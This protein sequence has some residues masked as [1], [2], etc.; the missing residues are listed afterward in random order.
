MKEWDFARNKDLNPAKLTAGS[1]KKAWWVCSVCGH[2]WQTAIYHRATKNTGCPN[3]YCGKR[4][5]FRERNLSVTHPEIAEDW[6]IA[7]NGGVTPEM[8]TKNS[9]Y[10]ASWKCAMCGMEYKSSVKNYKGCSQCR[11]KERLRNSNLAD[12]FPELAAEW[13]YERN[14]LHPEDFAPHSNQ[15][16]WWLCTKCG[17]NWR[18]KI[19]NRSAL[20]RNCP[21][22]AGR[23]VVTG[24]NDLATTHPHLVKEWHPV[25]N[26]ILTPQNVTHGSGKKVWWQCPQGH[27]YK[28]VILHRT[29]RESAT[30]CPICYSGRQTSFAEQATFYYIKKAFPDAI[31]RYKAAFLERFELDIFI[32]SINYAIEY[33]GEAWHKKDKILREQKK[34]EICRKHGIKLI[35]LRE[36]SFDT[37][38][39][40]ADFEIVKKDLYKHPHL[41]L[42]VQN[43]FNFLKNVCLQ[44]PDIDI[45]GDKIKVYQNYRMPLPDSFLR[46]FPHIAKEWH[47]VKNDILSPDMFKPYSDAKVWWQCA[48]CGHEWNA[49]IGHRASGTGCPECAIEKT[50]RTT[51]KAVYMIDMQTNKM[52]K[53]FVSISAAARETQ[54][55]SSNITMVCKGIRASAGGYVWKY[56]ED[57][58]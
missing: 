58:D 51:R 55:N 29:S 26:H 36:K 48:E 21:C 33:D 4:A 38:I 35:R 2:K 47:P 20:R 6:D 18:A 17:Y 34:Y 3:C 15:S 16:V 14:Q 19:S 52:I 40:I 5:K 41:T 42:G 46:Q 31:N 7:K 24:I 43:L 39:K 12:A 54:I 11:K 27:E 30:D 37:D 9:R 10:I 49:G 22:C 53:T 44:P 50:I 32:P 28:A 8:F 23:V 1:N 13:D 25:K 57:K 56:A 45:A